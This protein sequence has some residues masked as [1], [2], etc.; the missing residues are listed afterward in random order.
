MNNLFSTTPMKVLGSL[1][2][3]MFLLALGSYASLNF[4]KM[5]YLDTNP[6]VISVTGEGEV[7]A[8]PDV[9]QFTFSVQAEAADAAAAQEQSGTAVNEIIAFLRDQGVAE[10]DIKTTN[11]NLFPRYR[12]EER[13]CTPGTFCG[14][15]ERIQDGF[16]VS[17]S[18]EVKVRDTENASAIVTGVGERG[19]T[20]ISGLDFVVDD[21]DALAAQAREQAIID[22]KE[23][24]HKLASD[25]GV[26]LV[27]ITGFY[28]EDS[29]YMP[30][31]YQARNMAF[32]EKADSGFGGAELPMGEDQTI[33]RVTITYEIK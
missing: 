5:Q 23:K 22:A 1:T 2:V 19:A 29:R 33:A 25:L 31:P 26:R 7:F 32:D 17:Q 24:A 6:A 11:Y 4:E 27:K 15:G 16:E 12:F 8:V 21:T 10:E 20:N 14:P 18:I 28:E 3:F 13:I 30:E 9:G